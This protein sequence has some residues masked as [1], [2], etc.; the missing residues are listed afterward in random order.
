[1]SSARAQ[2]GGGSRTNSAAVRPEVRHLPFA[3][4]GSL[5]EI[6]CELAWT[7][8]C[9]QDRALEHDTWALGFLSSFGSALI[10]RPGRVDPLNGLSADGVFA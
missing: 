6:V 4:L 2:L 10:G 7:R 3:D 1:M 5:D 8:E 9:H